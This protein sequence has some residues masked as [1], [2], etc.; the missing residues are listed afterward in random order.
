[1][2][3]PCFVRS[4]AFGTSTRPA[5]IFLFPGGLWCLCL[6]VCAAAFVLFRSH[7]SASQQ[8]TPSSVS[9][10]VLSCLIVALLYNVQLH[11]GVVWWE[12]SAPPL[13]QNPLITWFC[14]CIA[15]FISRQCEERRKKSPETHK[16]C[17]ND[18]RGNAIT[19][20][21][22]T[23]NPALSPQWLLLR[24]NQNQ[25]MSVHRSSDLSTPAA[26]P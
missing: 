5:L 7:M 19:G 6:W 16:L 11:A 12:T 10:R 9:R 26:E 8:Q 1:M 25:G 22:F 20:N 3:S 21:T 18:N 14:L 24:A 23:T 4:S 13:L 17:P 2:Q 15:L